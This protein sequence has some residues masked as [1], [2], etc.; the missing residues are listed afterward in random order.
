MTKPQI[1]HLLIALL[2][3]TKVIKFLPV[4]GR[5]IPAPPTGLDAPAG[6]GVG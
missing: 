2:I 6:S 1:S 5:D 3:V 4:G